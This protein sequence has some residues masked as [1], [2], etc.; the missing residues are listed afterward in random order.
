VDGGV[1]ACQKTA[2]DWLFLERAQQLDDFIELLLRRDDLFR[3]LFDVHFSCA[4][5]EVDENVIVC[6][7]KKGEKNT[8]KS[9]LLETH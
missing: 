8:D 6:D 2:G 7:V 5:L 1:L 9:V 4:G 3:G